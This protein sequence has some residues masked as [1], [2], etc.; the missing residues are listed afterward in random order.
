MIVRLSEYIARK[1]IYAE[2]YAKIYTQRNLIFYFAVHLRDM[3]FN[4]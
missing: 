3:R 4:H 1:E 2:I